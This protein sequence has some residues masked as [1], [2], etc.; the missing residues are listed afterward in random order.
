L[1]RAEGGLSGGGDIYA[2][3]WIPGTGGSRD[4]LSQF[5]TSF[6]NGSTTG[7]Q[8]PL[9]PDGRAI[10]AIVPGYV[11]ARPLRRYPTQRADP[12]VGMAVHLDGSSGVPAAD[13]YAAPGPIRDPAGRL[14]RGGQHRGQCG[15]R[16]G[17]KLPVVATARRWSVDIS[18]T[19]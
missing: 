6:A 8:V 4:V 5:N 7:T 1:R 17:Q 14:P 15:L 11:D 16:L 9:Y 10:Y 13:L 12:R 18:P 2:Q 3:E 19:R